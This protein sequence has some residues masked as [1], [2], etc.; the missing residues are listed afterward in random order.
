MTSDQ[1]QQ[2]QKAIYRGLL[3]VALVWD[4]DINNAKCNPVF[5]HNGALNYVSPMSHDEEVFYFLR[6]RALM[7]EG[8]DHAHRLEFLFDKLGDVADADFAKGLDFEEVLGLLAMQL[9]YRFN[10]LSLS[11]HGETR[12]RTGNHERDNE[13]NALLQQISALG[14]LEDMSQPS[15]ASNYKWTKKAAPMLKTYLFWDLG[16]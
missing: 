7:I 12:L 6:S 14:Y 13:V 2:L 8:H 3:R 9:A 16:E 5:W 11:P 4:V 10:Y 15:A 1:Q